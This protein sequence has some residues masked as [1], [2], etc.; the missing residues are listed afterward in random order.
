M[1][2][3]SLCFTSLPEHALDG[4]RRRGR[5][6]RVVSG[7]LGASAGASAAASSSAGITLSSLLKNLSSRPFVRNG[8]S[9]RDATTPA[10]GVRRGAA[11]RRQLHCR[12]R[13]YDRRTTMKL[14][15][16]KA[17]I[18]AIAVAICSCSAPQ[19]EPVGHDAAVDQATKWLNALG[20]KGFVSK[21]TS[22]DPN[23]GFVGNE[24]LNRG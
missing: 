8:V 19:D 23:R 13:T 12:R 3:A 1:H 4:L 9:G 10:T 17:F 2:R 14:F 22:A 20:D 7:G 15:A 18:A 24:S 21:V 11:R 5:S 16:L 6:G